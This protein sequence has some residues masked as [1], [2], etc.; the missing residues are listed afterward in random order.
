MASSTRPPSRAASTTGAP[1]LSRLQPHI[2]PLV[3]PSPCRRRLLL[4]PGG[5]KTPHLAAYLDVPDSATLPMG[6][7]RDAH[8]TLTIHNQKEPSRNVV[9]GAPAA[10][11]RGAP[12]PAA[13]ASPPRVRRRRRPPVQRARLRLGLSGVCDAGGAPR[14]ELWLCGKRRAYG[15]GQAA[16]KGVGLAE[17]SGPPASG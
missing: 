17:A 8:F 13:T 12:A 3:R 11:D 7:T 6:W 2:T 14:C 1:P 4:F 16:R 5:N 10:F 9:K 15:L